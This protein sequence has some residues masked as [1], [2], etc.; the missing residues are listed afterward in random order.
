MGES[1]PSFRSQ[2]LRR[3]AGQRPSG[4]VADAARARS[5]SWSALRRSR[6][7]PCASGQTT[8]N[9]PAAD[10]STARCGSTAD[11][12]SICPL[13]T[14]PAAIAAAIRSHDSAPHVALAMSG[15]SPRNGWPILGERGSASRWE[16]QRVDRRSGDPSQP[17]PVV[18]SVINSVGSFDYQ[19]LLIDPTEPVGGPLLVIVSSWHIRNVGSQS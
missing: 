18:S 13:L 17:D 3:T 12:S 9:V 4:S 19:P 1:S 10:G 6:P 7:S 8:T 15:R 11:T 14:A 16:R 5:R 2:T